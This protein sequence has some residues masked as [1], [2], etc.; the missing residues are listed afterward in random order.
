MMQRLSWVSIAFFILPLTTHGQVAEK[1]TQKGQNLVYNPS[2]EEYYYCP[3]PM[4]KDSFPCKGWK[5]P[6]PCTPDYHHI[7]SR[8]PALKV[9]Q[10]DAGYY[11][12]KTGNAYMG[13]G[14]ITIETTAM[15]H[16]LGQL[17][18]PLKRG[19][20]Y[21]VSFWVRLAHAYSDYAAYNIGAYFSTKP[22]LSDKWKGDG[23]VERITPNLTAHV[24]NPKGNFITDTGWVEISGIYTAKG[25]EKYIT[26]G[27]FWDDHPKVVKAWEKYQKYESWN[28]MKRLGKKI[29]K[30][31]LKKNPHMEKQYKNSSSKGNY[32]FPYYFIDDVSVVELEE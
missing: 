8:E 21:R 9:P 1:D 15:E 3:P 11:L 14:L 26:I 30:H 12:P 18:E 5:P 27:M 32:H 10:T 19:K 22:I 13:F 6:Y 31:L 25:G 17:I 29:K 20:T 24:S 16:I 7:C 23:Y 28:A 2:F 4:P